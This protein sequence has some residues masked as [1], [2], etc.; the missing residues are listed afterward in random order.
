MSIYKI[1]NSE[2]NFVYVGKTDRTLCSRLSKHENDYGKWL[3]RG[4]RRNYLTSF[5]ILKYTGY[6]IELLEIVEF[7]S[8]LDEREKYYINHIECVNIIHNKNISSP[9]FLCPCGETVDSTFR[10]KHSK[11]R[12]HRRTIKEVHSKSKSRLYFINI[13]KNSKIEKIPMNGLTLNID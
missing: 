2:N 7:P 9:T 8:L 4:C 5:E 11:S 12:T 3:N 6:K 1:T 10:F 13:Y